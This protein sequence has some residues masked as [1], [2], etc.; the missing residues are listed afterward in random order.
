MTMAPGHVSAL[1]PGG[2]GQRAS[3]C[4]TWPICNTGSG[5]IYRRRSHAGVNDG[6]LR[7]SFAE[8]CAAFP[9]VDRVQPPARQRRGYPASPI[10]DDSCY[11]ECS[12]TAGWA[13]TTLRLPCSSAKSG[14]PRA[15]QT[16]SLTN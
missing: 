3:N 12:Y 16:A 5:I 1:W 9:I 13:R 2:G 4:L 11:T 15:T 14:V 8:I 7:Q 6:N 10:G